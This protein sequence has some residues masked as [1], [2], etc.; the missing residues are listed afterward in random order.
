MKHQPSLVRAVDLF[1][2]AGGSSYGARSA[3]ATI[4]GGV[5]AWG[6]AITTFGLNY[7]HAITRQARIE[8]ISAKS[9]AREVGKVDLL[10]ASPECTNHTFAKGNRR[11]GKEQEQSRRTA[12]EVIRFARAMEPRWI[13]VENVISMRNWEHY[14]EW[15][16]KMQSLGYRIREIVLDAQEFGVAQARRRLFVICDRDSEPAVPA[17]SDLIP[18]SVVDIL[19]CEESNG[20]SYEMKKLFGH[21][22]PRAKDT[23]L[24]ARRA[25]ES[26]GSN[27]PFLIVYYGTDAAG[28]WQSLDRPLRTITTLD[29]FALVRPSPKGHFMRMLQ[30]PELAKAMGFPDEYVW[31]KTTRRE[32]IKL[33][34][35]A[36]SPPVMKAVV[37]ALVFNRG[38]QQAPA[39][40]KC[41]FSK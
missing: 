27:S 30:P 32:R 37:G 21:R 19:H 9:F 3:G 36:V 23:L 5:D 15:R 25:I 11:D 40:S 12:F 13:V 10:L 6:T 16:K 8:T 1:C 39:K 7:P 22:P 35:N 28:G 31:P 2:G 29:R 20:F 17:T 18:P 34:G 4:V 38:V 41:V 24:R 26:L 14:S 33:V